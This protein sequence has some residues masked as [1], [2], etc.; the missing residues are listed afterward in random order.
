M[1]GRFAYAFRGQFLQDCTDIIGETLLED[2]YVSKLSDDLMAY[3]NKL[4]EAAEE[5]ARKR[6]GIDSAAQ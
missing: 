4:L 6:G 5:Y 1:P 2:G 3:G